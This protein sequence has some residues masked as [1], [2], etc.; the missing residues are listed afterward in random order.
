MLLKYKIYD[1]FITLC[2][3]AHFKTIMQ[4]ISLSTI[5]K[6]RKKK[7]KLQIRQYM[8]RLTSQIMLSPST[9]SVMPE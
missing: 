3:E 6:E 5:P 4:S 8:N 1:H 7:K 9:W 2:F